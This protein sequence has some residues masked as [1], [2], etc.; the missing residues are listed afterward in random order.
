MNGKV[1]ELRRLLAER[2]PSPRLVDRTAEGPREPTGVPALDEALGGGLPRGEFTEVVAAGTGTGS[3]QIWHAWLRCVAAA[4]RFLALVDGADSFDVAAQD[5]AVL[6]RLLWVR[7]RRAG[8]ALQATDLILRDRN[9][10]LVA[11]DLKLNPPAELRRIPS[12][13]WHRF[14]RLLEH[15]AATVMVV[16]PVPLVS[17]A[18]CRIELAPSL[19]PASLAHPAPLAELRFTVQHRPARQTVAELARAG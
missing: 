9:F 8:E 19:T 3:A 13:V 1:I 15:S 17:G 12:S 10:P 11:L 4:G 18:A 5:P 2:F 16:S 14:K 7:C 6:A